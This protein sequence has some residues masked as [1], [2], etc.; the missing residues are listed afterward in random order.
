MIS[1]LVYIGVALISALIAV[2]AARQNKTS[3]SSSSIDQ[4]TTTQ[5]TRLPKYFGTVRVSDPKVHWVGDTTT[6]A[7][8][9]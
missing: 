2:Y 6:T 4:P 3:A 8:K 1:L 5:G 7:V 9:K